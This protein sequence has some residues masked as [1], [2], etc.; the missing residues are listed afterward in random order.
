MHEWYYINMY[1]KNV[2]LGHTESCWSLI[3][4]GALLHILLVQNIF[5]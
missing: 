2:F 3:L 4:Y 5:I 1:V